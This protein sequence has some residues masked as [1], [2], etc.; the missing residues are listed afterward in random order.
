MQ[1]RGQLQCLLSVGRPH[2]VVAG[3]LKPKGNELEDVWIVVGNENDRPL[4]PLDDAHA[5]T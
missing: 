2:D 5:A 1:L 4:P 3:A